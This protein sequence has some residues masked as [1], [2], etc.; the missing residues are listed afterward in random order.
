MTLAEWYPTIKPTHVAL[1]A[2]SVAL[3]AARGAGVL[4]GARWPMAAAARRLSVAVDVALLAAG[5]LL[6][7]TLS[8]NPGRDAWLGTKLVLIVAY[9]VLGSFALKRARTPAGRAA[10]FAAALACIAS[11]AAIA[12]AHDPFAPWRWIA[13]GPPA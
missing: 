13:G 5:V 6:W 3:F 12:W 1:A 8:L 7:V 4:V 11:V 10:C 9:I 2:A